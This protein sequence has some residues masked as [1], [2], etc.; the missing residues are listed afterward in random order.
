MQSWLVLSI[1]IAA[2]STGTLL[3]GQPTLRTADAAKGH[4]VVVFAPGELAPGEVAVATRESR[5]ANGGF[6]RTN[7]RLIE[8][9]TG[10][11]EEPGGFVRFRTHGTVPRG[12]YY[13]AVSGFLQEPPPS[14]I[15]LGSHCTERWSNVRRI[16][17]R[18]ATH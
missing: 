3:D 13:V 17:V 18:S 10:T 7:R 4:V 2:V 9:I 11:I 16:V 12:V 8:R 15:P 6:V 14:C 5:T 1:G